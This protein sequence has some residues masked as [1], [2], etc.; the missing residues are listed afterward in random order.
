MD[1]FFKRGKLSFVLDGG[2]GSSAKGL[3]GAHIWKYHKPDHTT[4]A[5][6][7]F[8]E[9]AAHTI[10]HK[11]GKE[12]IHQ[13]LSSITS[14][15]KYE[16]Q[17][18][19]PGCVFAA[20]TIIKEIDL[21]SLKPDKL[22]I[23]PNAVI[24]TQ[25]DIDY[26]RGICDFEGTPKPDQD[27]ANLRIGSTLHGVGAA[28][29]RRV[30]RRSDVVL[31]K[32]IKEL[33]PFICN[34]Q[35]EIMNR[36]QK[37]ESGLMEIAQ[38]Y[39]LGLMSQFYP[40]CTSRNCSIAAALDDSLL[41]PSIIGPVTVNFRTFPIRV[42]S[43]KYIRKSDKKILTW[44]EVNS[45]PTEDIELIK[46]DSGSCY[47][48]QT[49]LT[50]EDISARAGKTIFEQ[51]SLTKLPRRVYSF[52]LQNLKEALLYN[53]TGHEMFISINFINYIDATVENKNKPSDVLT[54]T[55]QRWLCD[56]VF[57]E[58]LWEHY[59]KN[60]INIRGLFLGTGRCI[61]DSILIDPDI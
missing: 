48:D 45:T 11:D 44:S 41:P 56:N 43:N 1:P 50:W 6:N 26:E 16:K 54:Q 35:E 3:R 14:V 18:L 8:M 10:T 25:K 29:A 9:N 57:S 13:C 12:Y 55:V 52:S 38:G 17:Y 53:N 42:N 32:D 4:F 37:G 24:V 31:A 39:Q 5:V 49:E 2:A 58:E 51:T 20:E 30:L 46:G 19:S 60:K 59:S 15:G 33:Q 23:H 7:T 28:R 27:S 47:P 34:T 36:L 40:K 61:E 21:F 22:G